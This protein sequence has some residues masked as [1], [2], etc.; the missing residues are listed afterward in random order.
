VHSHQAVFEMTDLERAATLVH[1][2]LPPTPQFAWPKLGKRAGCTVWV[3]HENHTPTG[4]FKVRGGLVYLDRLRH[5]E[6]KTS[7]VITATRGNHGQ[8]IAFAAA[9]T[10][11]AATIYVPHNNSSDQNSAIAAF[12]ARVVEFGKDFDE[13]RHEASRVAAAE[14]LHFVPSFHR[15]LVTGV[16]TYA[17]ELFHSVSNL[18]AVYVGV[19]MGSG[20]AGLITVR[21]LLGLKTEIVGVGA[22][23]APATAL[24]FAARRPVNAPSAST[25]ADGIATREPNAEAVAT[26][27]RGAARIV[28]VAENEIAE[29]MRIY[30]DDTHQ[31]AEGAGAA[32]LAALLQERRKMANKNVAVVLSGGNIERARFLQVLSGV[33]PSAA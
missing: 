4:A 26:I 13:A 30:F 31:I 14:G 17:L 8:S 9:R 3:K 6:P 1:R 16:A 21:D 18:D 11:V 15:D 24:S 19:G 23:T 22:V 29:A 12:G 33:T 5:A 7:G 28:E 25:F 27:C 20:I 10:R 2:V 32:P